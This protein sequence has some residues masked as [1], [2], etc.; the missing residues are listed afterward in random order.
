MRAVV[1]RLVRRCGLEAVARAFPPGDSKLLAHVRRQRS[2]RERL[3]GSSQVRGLWEHARWVQ[4]MLWW[5]WW[6][7]FIVTGVCVVHV[8]CTYASVHC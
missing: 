2:R 5:H 7:L 3:R 1:E 8:R 6:G 4:G